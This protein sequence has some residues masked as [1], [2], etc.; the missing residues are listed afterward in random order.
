M[1]HSTRFPTLCTLT[2]D[3]QALVS[4]KFPPPP[5]TNPY[6]WRLPTNDPRDDGDDLQRLHTLD[7]YFWMLDDANQFMDSIE[8]VLC[9]A[10]IETDR[11][12]VPP[13]DNAMSTVVRKLEDVAVTD[14]GYQN[15]QTRNSRTEPVSLAPE[16]QS[17]STASI[18]PPPPPGIP[19]LAEHQ[20][21]TGAQ[22]V[23]EQQKEPVNF[24][25]LPYNPVAPA[26]PEP[27]QHRE[28]TPPPVDG[29]GGTGLAAAAAADHGVPYNPHFPG[30]ASFAPPPTQAMSYSIP[31]SIPGNYASPPPSAGLTHSG[32]FSSR[33]S[34]QNPQGVPSYQSQFV[35]GATQQVTQSG[36]MS[37][38]PPPVDPHANL[39]GQNI[40]GAPPQ[41][42]KSYTAPV[43]GYSNYI[44]EQAPQRKTSA[45][46]YDVHSQLYRPPKQRPVRITRNMPSKR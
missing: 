7:I 25:P 18:L 31:G 3:G 6:D 8:R 21:T 46:E 23:P 1:R 44:Y 5:N 40:Y 30:S 16:S 20:S 19:P 13:A 26:A 10:R 38:A 35:P 32:S 14:P 42:Q 33:S 11:H 43:G 22:P 17:P 37:F 34:I 4:E 24:T 27:I 39:Y 15:G 29:A 41:P 36:Q 45:N 28:K 12:H 9:H 2:V